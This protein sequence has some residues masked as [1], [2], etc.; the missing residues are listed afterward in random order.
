MWRVGISVAAAAILLTNGVIAGLWSNRWQRPVELELGTDR[1]MRVP[2]TIGA[3]HAHSEEINE[4]ALAQAGI[5]GYLFRH[6]EHQVTRKRITVLLT[7][8]RPGPIA[9]HTPDV[10]YQGA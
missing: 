6:Y 10:C 2:M 9:L 5:E 8:G 4:A 3:W 7:C 1:L